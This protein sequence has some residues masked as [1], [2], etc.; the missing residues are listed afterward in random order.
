M[1]T[2][3]T[4][5][6]TPVFREM[7]DERL[8]EHASRVAACV[9]IACEPVA[10]NDISVTINELRRR[11][12]QLREFVE[13]LPKTKDGVPKFIGDIVW[14]WMADGVVEGGQSCDLSRPVSAEVTCNEEG[15]GLVVYLGIT[16]GLAPWDQQT[17]YMPIEECWST[18]EACLAANTKEN[19]NA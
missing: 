18:K 3:T 12:Y 19:P 1:T 13:K 8:L 16:G 17:D 11:F 14:Y 4:P 15:D 9:H 2:P 5:P 7:S 10:A 6:A